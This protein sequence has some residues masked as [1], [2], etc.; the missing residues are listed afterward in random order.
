MLQEYNSLYPDL[1]LNIT[2][3]A[4]GIELL[5]HLRT[6]NSFDI[7]LLDV[8]MPGENGIELGLGIRE[9][10]QAGHIIYLTTSPDFAIDAYQ[11]K[12]FDYMLKPPNKNRLFPT[13]NAIMEQFRQEKQN[14][15]TIKSR[16]G[17]R[18]LPHHCIIYGELVKRCVQYNLSDGSVLESMSL[19]G[20]FKDAVKPLLN[21]QRFV[22]CTFSFFV[23]LSFVDMIEPT[24]L[25]L[26]NGKVLPLSRAFRAKVTQQ[27]LDYHLERR[28]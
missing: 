12:A 23:N 27:W 1:E 3:F 4:F 11:V 22:L 2:T 13:L 7:Y 24:S 28:Y 18:R 19:R 20:S 8:I 9:L 25:R 15:V 6:K 26:T 16:D 17:L 14:F 10:D 21:N 5:E